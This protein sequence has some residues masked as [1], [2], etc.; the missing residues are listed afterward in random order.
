MQNAKSTKKVARTL[1]VK[2]FLRVETGEYKTFRSL[3]LLL[4]LSPSH[5]FLLRKGQKGSS[6]CPRVLLE[7]VISHRMCRRASRGLAILGAMVSKA[8]RKL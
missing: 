1:H 6:M 4:L 3:L 5:P 2:P 8:E 7:N